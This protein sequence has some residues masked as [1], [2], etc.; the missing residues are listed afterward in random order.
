MAEAST[1]NP[2]ARRLGLPTK[3]I[4]GFG[5]VA[6]GT[7]DNGFSTFLLIFYNQVVGLPAATVGL[8]IMV[9]LVTDAFLDPIVG[10]ISDNWRSRW[11]RRHPFMYASALPVAISYSLL[12][13]P[14]HGWGQGALFAYLI[15]TAILIRSFIS[16]YEIPSTALSA[17]LTSDYDERTSLISFRF[18]FLWAG[19]LLMYFLAFKVILTPDATHPVGQLNPAGYSTYG[20]VAGAIMLVAILV[21]AVGTHRQIPYLRRPPERRLTLKA[22]VGEMFEALAHR[23]FLCLMGATL[24]F[25]TAVGLGFSIGTYFYTFF[26]ELSSAQIAVFTFSSLVGAIFAFSL[27]PRVSALFPSK[28]AGAL[29]LV[30]VAA[31]VAVSP[32]LL[33]L[34]GVVPANG[35]A[36]IMPLLL[37]A[38]VLSVF[39][40][41][42]GAILM[43]SMIADVVE[44]SELRT[45]R[46]QEGLFFAAAAFI[47]KAVSGVGIFAAS[48]LLAL[49][50]FPEHA[51]PGEVPH[52]VVRNLGLVYLPVLAI[53]YLLSLICMFG[54]RITREGHAESLRKLAAAADL[55]VEGEPLSIE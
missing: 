9:A 24:F 39:L 25:A 46:R 36:V 11:G 47:N 38:G 29:V 43:T 21:S 55:A 1:V 6:F 51:K 13:N 19:G 12:W 14:P 50:H 4:Y 33:R 53:L 17:E 8:A 35:S 45:G 44:D 41:T 54:Y 28:R 48:V 26:W 52:E 10:Q 22:L 42:A 27:T 23:S 40:G 18:L 30:P 32:I 34:V 3:L 5:T 20:V 2:A 15:A 16:W 7:K 49:V 37:G 31:A